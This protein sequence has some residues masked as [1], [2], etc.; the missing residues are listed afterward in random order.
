MPKK[1]LVGNKFYSHIKKSSFDVMFLMFHSII[2]SLKLYSG[3]KSTLRIRVLRGISTS[4]LKVANCRID[5]FFSCV[6]AQDYDVD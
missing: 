6:K 1:R 2:F 5:Y 3:H 4:H